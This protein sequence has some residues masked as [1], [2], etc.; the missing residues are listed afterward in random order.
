MRNFVETLSELMEERDLT[1][2]KLSKAVGISESTISSWIISANFVSLNNLIKLADFFRCSID[3]LLGRN[4]AF[5]PFTISPLIPF[6]KRIR[7]IMTEKGYTR[8]R[9][10]KETRFKEA[11]I[12]IWDKGSIPM[13]PTLIELADLFDCSV[14]YLIGRER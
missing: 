2:K 4:K 1:S 3:Y 12:Y 11:H 8:Y 9:F 5:L 7:E 10:V 14:D 6:S 13:L